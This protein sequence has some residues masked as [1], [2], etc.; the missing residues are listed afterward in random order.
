MNGLA[1]PASIVS[2]ALDDVLATALSRK[3]PPIAPVEYVRKALRT[4]VGEL[5]IGRVRAVTEF[6]IAEQ[7]AEERAELALQA[8][9]ARAQAEVAKAR[10]EEKIAELRPEMAQRAAEAKQ[11]RKDRSAERGKQRSRS[12]QTKTEIVDGRER[13][14]ER[15]SICRMHGATITGVD[16]NKVLA[17]HSD[18]SVDDV[19]EAL[20]IVD[21]YLGPRPNKSGFVRNMAA[22]DAIEKAKRVLHSVVGRRLYGDPETL[23][24]GKAATVSGTALLNDFAAISQIKLDELLAKYPDATNRGSAGTHSDP[25]LVEF[26]A[27]RV[28]SAEYGPEQQR[29]VEAEFEATIAKLD[30]KGRKERE[31]KEAEERAKAEELERQCSHMER[32]GLIQMPMDTFGRPLFVDAKGEYVRPEDI[33]RFGGASREFVK[34]L[35]E[36]YR[37]RHGPL[38]AGRWAILTAPQLRAELDESRR[39]FDESRR[40]F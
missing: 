8:D 10:A 14:R 39:V 16:A 7:Q 6:T 25:L 33:E 2:E 29:R 30:E 11:K 36:Q 4:R 38:A 1:A 35:E 3:E 9:R 17:S 15:V 21:A 18:A 22:L 20:K 37:L 13:F 19:M 31:F 12:E 26:E 28:C 34:Q 27:I 5:L 23:A 32:Y 24:G 40:V